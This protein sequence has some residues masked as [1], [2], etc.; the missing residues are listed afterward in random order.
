MM[1]YETESSSDSEML[2]ISSNS[3]AI[4]VLY[5]VIP[6]HEISKSLGRYLGAVNFSEK[7][8]ISFFCEPVQLIAENSKSSRE[9]L[10]I[11]RERRR[12]ISFQEALVQYLQNSYIVWT[13]FSNLFSREPLLNLNHQADIF[14]SLKDQSDIILL[15][16][17]ICQYIHFIEAK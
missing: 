5:R 4:W 13:R 9:Y 17:Y 16:T 15:I 3:Y 6:L 12:F 7:N 2:N 8:A 10:P 1:T 11:A 14:K